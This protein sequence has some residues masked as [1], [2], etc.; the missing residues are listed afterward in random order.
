M[1]F[2]KKQTLSILTL[3]AGI[4]LLSTFSREVG[5][6]PSYSYSSCASL[7]DGLGEVL[8]PVILGVFFS[9]LTYLMLEEVYRAWFKFAWWWIP[10]SMLLIFL[11]PEYSSDWLYPVE[12]GSVAFISCILFAIISIVII[13]WKY[14]SRK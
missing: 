11:S 14:F 1:T 6:C 9:I 7:F 12:K 10:L 3:G 13:A 4:F 2:N 8:L 5:L